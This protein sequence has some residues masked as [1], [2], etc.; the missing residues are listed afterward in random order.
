MADINPISFGQTTDLLG[1]AIKGAGLENAQISNNL[2]NVN[3]PNY[4][5]STTNF[6]DALEAS[7]GTPASTDELTLATDND[8]QFTLDGAEMPV[9]FDPQATVDST[10]QMRVDGSNVDVDQ[11]MAK[12]SEN[13][14]YSQ[15]MSQLLQEQYKF[16]REAITEQTN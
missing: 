11:E 13:T 14:G 12:L 6:K 4:R 8:R 1:N 5:R 7:L 3:T 10:V 15:T 2:A 16:F 9:A